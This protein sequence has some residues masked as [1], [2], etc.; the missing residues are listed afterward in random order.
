MIPNTGPSVSHMDWVVDTCVIAATNNPYD[1]DY[2]DSM[3][4]LVSI[5]NG[6]SIAVDSNGEIYNEYDPHMPF[7]SF[8]RQW[9]IKITGFAKIR[10]LS[11]TLPA[12]V[13]KHLLDALAFHDDDI[14]FVSVAHRTGSRRLVSKDSDY[15]PRVVECLKDEL[16]I[17]FYDVA[18]ARAICW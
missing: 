7:D 18:S 16:S 12:S 1:S 3:S 14:K 15:N 5:A 17:T 9:W 10:F 6:H 4:L 8:A 13:E 2:W 11:S